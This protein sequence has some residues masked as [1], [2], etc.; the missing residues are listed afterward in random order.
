MIKSFSQIVNSMTAFIR[1]KRPSLQLGEG[2]P[3]R[4]VVIDAPAQEISRLYTSIDRAEQDQS[5]RLA[6][7]VGLTRA[8]ENYGVVRKSA[9]KAQGSVRFFSRVAPSNDIFIAAGSVV[10]TQSANN[11]VSSQFLTT[12]SATMFASRASLYLNTDTGYYE[13]ELPVEALIAGAQNNVGANTVT[14]LITNISGINGCYNSISMSGGSDTEDIELYRLRVASQMKGSAFG[15]ADGYLGIVKSLSGVIDAVVVGNGNTQRDV[16]GA[17]DIIIKGSISRGFTDVVTSYGPNIQNVILFKQPLIT[18]IAPSILS[19]VNGPVSGSSW[20]V[21]KDVGA[22]G[23][24][25]IAQ[26]TIKWV[27]DSLDISNGTLSIAYYYNGLIEDVQA[28]FAQT[29]YDVQN[30]SV[31]IRAAR[32]IPINISTT[33]KVLAGYS[34][35]NVLSDIETAV[36]TLLSNS[37][38]GGELQQGDVAREILN[39]PGVDD[40][41]LP[42]PVFVSTDGT[43]IK[44]SNNNLELPSDAVATPGI[45]GFTQ[46]V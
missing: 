6:T 23:G 21:Q 9:V 33:I 5:V 25:V 1:G 11:S 36:T 37:L 28:L 27:G 13:L 2:S 45:Y 20:S 22:F 10:A 39:V 18:T 31:L 24:S 46:Q 38:I 43:I 14:A 8:G 35:V 17:I 12:A 16:W 42:F 40:V 15:T 3:T 44:N 34:W 26:D 4:D 19:S 29:N 32:E 7:I 41:F 30:T